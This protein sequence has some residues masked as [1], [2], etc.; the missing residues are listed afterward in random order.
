MS[1]T[2]CRKS[3]CHDSDDYYYYYYYYDYAE[4]YYYESIVLNISLS[5]NYIF[6]CN[7]STIGVINTY[8]YIYNRTFNSNDPLTNLVIENGNIG[9]NKQCQFNIFLESLTQYILVVTTYKSN[10]RGLFSIVV[11]GPSLIHFSPIDDSTS[12]KSQYSSMLTK[13][14][15]MYCP[16]DSCPSS[17]HY[18]E[19][20]EFN[21]S[22]SGSY[23]ILCQS[24]VSISTNMYRNTFNPIFRS[25]NYL[26]YDTTYTN[27][28]LG[29][30]ITLNSMTK[31]ILIVTTEYYNVI[32][33]FTIIIKGPSSIHFVKTNSSLEMLSRYSS[34]LTNTSQSYA[35]PYGNLGSIYYYQCIEVNVSQSNNYSIISQS[36][37]RL[38]G[39]LYEN[40]FNP[41]FPFENLREIN[42][43][44]AGE[45]QFRLTKYLEYLIKYILVVTT[46][47]QRQVGSFSI[48]FVGSSSI[49]FSRMNIINNN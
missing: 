4:F 47:E 20:I 17:L 8:V 3:S 40:D 18:Y 25:V 27:C 45:E 10:Q 15:E 2:F 26:R 49:S 24:N 7:R 5:G 30:K 35:R 12:M 22:V 6:I 34:V 41:N 43:G 48:I 28:V 16:S 1:E 13:S 37:M 29:S 23:S 21:I 9:D 32:G 46:Y 14:S 44:G 33:L 42:F 38:F 19:S 36:N 11:T 31:Y 39:Y